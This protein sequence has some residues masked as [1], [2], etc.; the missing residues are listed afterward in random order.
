M[1]LRSFWLQPPSGPREGCEEF[2]DFEA[3]SSRSPTRS[4]TG[5]PR[6]AVYNRLA[7][8]KEPTE[9]AGVSQKSLKELEPGAGVEPA[10]Y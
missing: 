5:G 1:L 4:G 8:L 2:Q 7:E 3:S 9:L 6:Q 10:T